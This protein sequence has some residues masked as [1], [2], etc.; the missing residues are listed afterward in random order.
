[1]GHS[2]P[3]V[4]SQPWGRAPKTREHTSRAGGIPTGRGGRAPPFLKRGPEGPVRHQSRR[5]DLPGREEVWVGFQQ[6]R[7]AAFHLPHSTTGLPWP[8]DRRANVR[9][10]KSDWGGSRLVCGGPCVDRFSHT[11]WATRTCPLPGLQGDLGIL[12]ILAARYATIRSVVTPVV[13]VFANRTRPPAAPTPTPVCP[14]TPPPTRQSRR[15][16]V[17]GV[18]AWLCGEIDLWI[19]RPVLRANL[20]ERRR[21]W[22]RSRIPTRNSTGRVHDVEYNMLGWIC[23]ISTYLH[24]AL[25]IL[26]S[27]VL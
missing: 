8:T 14:S 1:M 26:L 13:L 24:D 6:L 10:S 22:P 27:Y 20:H 17:R 16:T 21:R 15:L 11:K 23:C 12:S 25:D 2:G 7:S 4:D 18:D 5:G 3:P 19:C 9:W